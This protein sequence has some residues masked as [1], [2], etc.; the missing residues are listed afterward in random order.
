MATE[1]GSN[2][3]G[4]NEDLRPNFERKL[5]LSKKMHSKYSVSLGQDTISNLAMIWEKGQAEKFRCQ[6][7][8]LAKHIIHEVKVF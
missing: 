1:H 7:W 6:V 8:K 5:N 4:L 2:K 3:R